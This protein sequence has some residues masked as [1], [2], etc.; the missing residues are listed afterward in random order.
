MDKQEEWFDKWF[1]SPYYHLLYEHRDEDEAALFL[2]NLFR[3]LNPPLNSKILDLACGNGRHAIYLNALGYE[4][5]GADLSANN[6]NQANNFSGKRLHFIRHDMRNPI[7]FGKFDMILNLFTS[8]GYFKNIDDNIKVIQNMSEALTENGS[9][10]ID[11]FNSKYVL[12]NYVPNET[13]VKSGIEFVIE[14]YISNNIMCKQIS[15]VH[16]QKKYTF[17]E[18]V[19]LLNLY[20][21]KLFLN[22]A[23]LQLIYT[24]GN[25]KLDAFNEETSERLILIAKK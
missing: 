12:K 21:F 23:K 11:F 1:D 2:E 9:I 10:V 8:I 3:F 25:Y 4:V 5:T 18:Q 16:H 17:T 24:F 6:I 7:N 15:F 22:A 14:R 13:V 20:D 19:S